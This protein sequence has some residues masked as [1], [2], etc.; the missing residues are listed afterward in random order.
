MREQGQSTL[1]SDGGLPGQPNRESPYG[2]SFK[3]LQ[4]PRHVRGPG[5]PDGPRG[6][7]R[8]DLRPAGDTADCSY[9]GGTSFPRAIFK[10]PQVVATWRSAADASVGFCPLRACTHLDAALSS[11]WLP[12]CSPA[13]IVNRFTAIDISGGGEVAN[14]DPQSAWATADG[15]DEHEAAPIP[16]EPTS[17]T[18]ARMRWG[19]QVLLTKSRF[20]HLRLTDPLSDRNSDP[21][22]EVPFRAHRDAGVDQCRKP[23]RFRIASLVAVDR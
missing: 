18:T 15:P 12:E 14:A 4:L 16:M 6:A 1:R 21:S 8:L 22:G 11:A 17:I 23:F 3:V 2:R 10:S 19:R 20:A 9:P 7:V 5:K 13:S